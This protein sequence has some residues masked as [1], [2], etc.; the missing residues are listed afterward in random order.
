MKA[1][2]GLFLLFFC[3]ESQAQFNWV[4]KTHI[5][6]P[7][8][9]SH[10]REA[11]CSASCAEGCFDVTG[12]DMRFWIMGEVDNLEDPTYAKKDVIPCTD[13]DTC[14]VE[15]KKLNCSQYING[16]LTVRSINNDEV[17]CAVPNG[18]NKKPDLVKDTAAEAIAIAE[19]AAK[20][21][22]QILVDRGRKRVRFG[23][24][25]IQ[26]L[27]GLFASKTMTVAQ[28]EQIFNGLSAIIVALRSGSIEVA[29]VK[30][31]ALVPDNVLLL[32]A[33]ID[34]AIAEIDKFLQSE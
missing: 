26:L 1:L 9:S 3:L 19:D 32:Q 28:R 23:E 27:Q 6:G 18:F 21:Q 16:T 8:W 22:K 34:L 33:D 11:H 13:F 5:E 20:A 30:I 10:A 12:K 2:I 7:G 15:F 24:A 29:K 17:Y 4:C 25:T 14:N 31:E